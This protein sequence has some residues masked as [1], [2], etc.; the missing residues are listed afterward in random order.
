MFRLFKHLKPMAKFLI[1]AVI[2]L[3]SSAMAELY[4]PGMMSDIINDGIFLDYEPMYE[5]ETMQNPFGEIDVTG[6][7]EGF[8]KDK[9]PVFEMQ[10]GFSTL[11]IKTVWNEHFSS[12]KINFNFKDIPVKDSK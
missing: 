10:D 3:F 12:Y 7:V 9:I 4:L 6:E 5:H 1:V 2:L 11:D 8:D